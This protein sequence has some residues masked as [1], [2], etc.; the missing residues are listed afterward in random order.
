MKNSPFLQIDKAVKQMMKL[1]HQKPMERFFLLT[2]PMQSGKT[3]FIEDMFYEIKKHYPKSMGLYVVSHNHKDFISQNFLRLEHLASIDLHC[4]TLRER[5]LGRIKQRPL[6]S[7]PNE[8]VF[9]FFD[10]NH[11]GDAVHQTIDQWLRFNK[12][13]PGKNVYFIG[14]S[15]TAFSSIQR[16]KDTTVLYDYKLMPLY[17]SVTAMIQRGDI[18]E[19]TPIIKI[20]NRKMVLIE[21]APAIKHLEAIVKKQNHGYAILRIPQKEHAV[22]LE[23]VLIRKFGKD[24]VHIR[25]WNQG[26]QIESPG[27][28]F[29]AYRKD[30]V[31]IVLIQQKARMGNTIPTKYV[32]MVYDYSPNA[33]VATVAQ[34]LLGR[35]CGHNKLN[36]N[37]KV[38]SHL[39]QAKAYS[40]FEL[41]KLQ[42]FYDF[43]ASN[44][45]KA[46]QRSVVSSD[47]SQGIITEVISCDSGE[48][49]Q[50]MEC[51][52]EQL[53]NKFGKNPMFSGMVIRRLSKNR[54]EKEGN[55][56]KDIIDRPL[57]NTANTKLLR[58]PGKV[59]VLVDDRTSSL[60]VYA[61][62]RLGEQQVI[63]SL[64][65][66]A[67]SIYSQ[68]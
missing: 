10:E 62:F 41:G 7:F 11:F 22:F 21:D 66:K 19:A 55:W 45:I 39:R 34:G 44:G 30:I 17:K 67:S 63:N 40:L 13:Y 50:V 68:I 43:I 6:K 12:L 59:S 56:Y 1:I 61:T 54:N 25:H 64:I 53:E 28:Y 58:D 37:V 15:A 2:A 18:E 16:A 24:K 20:E 57:D 27:D 52:K 65:P 14:V 33:A 32:H 5:R 31:T 29:N 9:I 60:T 48:K 49:K 42:E 38:F 3:Q 8:P 47:K 4:L 23:G 36:D 26:H 35:M 51:V 46:S